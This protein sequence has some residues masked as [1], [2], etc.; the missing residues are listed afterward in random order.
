MKQLLNTLFVMTE[1]SYVHIDHDNVL[2]DIEKKTALRVPIQHL[3]GLSVFGNVMVS[4]MTISRF[5][6]EGRGM[7]FFSRTGRFQARVQ[8][9]VSGNVLLRVAQFEALKQ[10]PKPAEISRNIVAAKIQNSRQILMRSARESENNNESKQL[11]EVANSLSPLLN[12]LSEAD[13]LDSIRGLEGISAK[14]YFS[15]FQYMIRNERDVFPFTKRSRRPPLDRTNALMSFLYSMLL[16]DCVSALEGV[17]LDPQIGYLHALRPGR[18]ALGLDLMEELRTVI[19]DRLALALMNRKQ[20]QKDD[21]EERSGGAVMLNEAGRKKVVVA[22]Q[23]RKQEEITHPVLENK[24]S[25][26]LLPHIQ[27]SLFARYLRQ[28]IPVYQPFLLR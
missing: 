20:I 15:V 13:D 22:Y 5:A 4:P 14:N 1:G 8:G 25:F 18:P 26:G 6:Q 3:S 27:A 19:S 24:V 16:N 7:A 11:R 28:D 17:G 21:F 23:K 10:I 2:V 12:K 9:S